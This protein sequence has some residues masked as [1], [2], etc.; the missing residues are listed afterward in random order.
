MNGTHLESGAIVKVLEMKFL[1]LLTASLGIFSLVATGPLNGQSN[2]FEAIHISLVTPKNDNQLAEDR[3]K[4]LENFCLQLG[5]LMTRQQGLFGSGVFSTA[6]CTVNNKTVKAASSTAIW[7]ITTRFSKSKISFIIKYKSKLEGVFT[8]SRPKDLILLLSNPD[9]QKLI[10]YGIHEKLPALFLVSPGEV[11]QGK[12]LRTIP[13]NSKLSSTFLTPPSEITLY[14]LQPTISNLWATSA[15]SMGGLATQSKSGQKQF[16]WQFSPPS[17]QASTSLYAHSSSGRGGENKKVH[18]AMKMALDELKPDGDKSTPIAAAIPV[19]LLGA[20]E[21]R[22]GSTGFRYGIQTLTGD[23]LL[24]KSQLFG[25]FTKFN[26]GY[27]QGIQLHYDVV[28]KVE[29]LDFSNGVGEQTTVGWERAT[30]GYSLGFEPGLIVDRIDFLPQ[31]GMWSFE[32]RLPVVFPEQATLFQE[33]K[34]SGQPIFSGEVGLEGQLAILH[35]RIYVGKDISLGI[36]KNEKVDSNRLGLDLNLNIFPSWKVLSSPVRLSLLGFYL[37]ES[38]SFGGI[39]KN[40]D[41]N[42]LKIDSL[43]YASAHLG[44]GIVLHW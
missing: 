39:E 18:D 11:R 23:Q 2:I 28:P 22:Y 20:G 40:S 13:A 12:F 15:I 27:L 4:I 33:F 1:L 17:N 43:A 31:I 9:T 6:S 21:P 3:E 34:T 36:R 26:D 8:V 38:I 7:N 10:A 35:Y 42:Q 14:T 19:E 29:Y 30:I 16:T 44:G 5:E 24:M 41:L 32:A 37:Y 25:F